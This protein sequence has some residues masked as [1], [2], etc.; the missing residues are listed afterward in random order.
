[1]NRT[2]E[3]KALLLKALETPLGIIVRL[4]GTE[5]GQRQS[6]IT[7]L[8]TVK[9]DL[10][11]DVPEMLDLQIQGVPGNQELIAIKRIQNEED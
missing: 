10:R 9:R 1:M 6:A 3:I 2:D 8:T 7:T 4:I 5:P 11:V